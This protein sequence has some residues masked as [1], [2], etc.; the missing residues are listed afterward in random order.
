MV[1]FNNH[2]QTH[3]TASCK[4]CSNTVVKTSMKAHKANCSQMSKEYKCEQCDYKTNHQ[5]P[6]KETYNSRKGEEEEEKF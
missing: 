4:I 1:K 2:S 6:Q 3:K 5:E